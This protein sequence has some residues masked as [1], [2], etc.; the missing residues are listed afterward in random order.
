MEKISKESAIKEIQ[1]FVKKFDGKS[2]KDYEVENDYPDFIQ[3]VTEGNIHF[4]EDG[5]PLM[6]L[7]EPIKNDSGD[8]AFDSVEFKHRIKPST[9]ADITKGLNISQNQYEYSIRCISYLTGFP[10]NILDKLSKR[11]WKTI[12]QI[13]SVFM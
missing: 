11:D 3:G 12:E 9:L 8:V 4:K 5:T 2:K 1:E 10:K 6:K 7:S 13:S